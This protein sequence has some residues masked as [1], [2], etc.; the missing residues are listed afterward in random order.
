MTVRKSIGSKEVPHVCLSENASNAMSKLLVDSPANEES[1]SITFDQ[2]IFV[3]EHNSEPTVP[4]VN[5][6]SKIQ[7]K[8]LPVHKYR[9]EILRAITSN[10]VVVISGETGIYFL[11]IFF[12]YTHINAF[13]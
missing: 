5:Q 1:T 2:N 10:Q 12:C 3:C 7:Q 8:E 13:I 4:P 6:T 11:S 9:R